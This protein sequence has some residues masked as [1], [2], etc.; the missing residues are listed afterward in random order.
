M[1]AESQIRRSHTR[2]WIEAAIGVVVLAAAIVLVWYVRS[3]RFADL[4]RRKTI[5]T[6]E[7]ATGGRVE[8]RAF[9]WNLSKLEFD[10]DDLTIHGLEAPDQQPYAH[11]DRIH[12]RLHIISFVE[13][14]ISLK[15]LSSAPSCRAPHCESRRDDQRPGTEAAQQ[16][17]R[18]CS[19]CSIWRSPASICTT[20]CCW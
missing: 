3:P 2:L 16:R 4:V 1:T 14:R 10:A 7:E 19:S 18:R 5:A 9:R 8:L 15:E 13:K 17:A 11:A 12:V 20:A 6:L